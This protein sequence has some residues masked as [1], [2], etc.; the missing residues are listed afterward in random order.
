MNAKT[1]TAIALAVFGYI[2]LNGFFML[3]S[4]VRWAGAFWTAKGV[5][6]DPQRRERLSSAPDRGNVRFAGGI[7]FLIAGYAFVAILGAY[8]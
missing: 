5:Y 8:R 6:Q 3:C 1:A 4:P 7:M 2:A